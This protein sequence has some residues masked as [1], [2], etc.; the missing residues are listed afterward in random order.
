MIPL[1]LR[2]DQYKISI[3]YQLMYFYSKMIVAH[4]YLKKFSSNICC[5]HQEIKISKMQNLCLSLSQVS[6]IKLPFVATV[7]LFVPF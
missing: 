7:T 4:V 6:V 5:D 3:Q 2:N 1:S